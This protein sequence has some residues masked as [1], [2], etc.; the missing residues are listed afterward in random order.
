MTKQQRCRKEVPPLS[1]LAI[2]VNDTPEV[3]GYYQAGLQALEAKDRDKGLIYYES[4]KKIQGSVY[5]DKATEKCKHPFPG[6]WDYMIEYNNE[7]YYYEPHPAT[8]G[9]K[10][11]E[12][13]G[14]ADWLLWWLKNN[15]PKIKALGTKGL[16]WVHTGTCSI[17]KNSQQYKKLMEKGVKL[18]SR[19]YMK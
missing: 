15:A 11:D 2:A 16:Y 3:A 13:C 14:K 10:I 4:P 1:P 8:G 17:D 19:L 6:R 5:L 7:I 9:G 12:V 18:D